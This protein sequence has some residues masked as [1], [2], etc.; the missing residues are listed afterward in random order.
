LVEDVAITR[1]LIG[2]REYRRA[3]SIAGLV[4]IVFLALFVAFPLLT[5]LTRE[6]TWKSFGDLFADVSLRHVI[7]FTTWQALLSTA[8]TAFVAAP[9]VWAL[10]RGPFLGHRVVTGILTMPFVMPTIVVAIA[11]RALLPGS[12][13]GLFPIVLAH[14]LFNVAVYV[15]IVVPRWLSIGTHEEDAARVLGATPLRI[16]TSVIWPQIRVAVRNASCIVGAFTFT[17]FGIIAVLGTSSQRTIELEVLRRATQIGDTSSAVALSFLQ[18]VIVGALL[19]WGSSRFVY[20]SSPHTHSRLRNQS[21]TSHTWMAVIA[22]S[23]S[24][25]VLLPFIALFVRSFRT[26]AGFTLSGWH[27]LI[28]GSL[29]PLGVDISGAVSHSAIFAFVC[30]VIAVPLAVAIS[31]AV[32]YWPQR[33]RWVQTVSFIPL[34]VSAVTLGFGVIITFD[35]APIEWR[36]HWW[37]LP[38]MHAVIAIPLCVRILIPVLTSVDN[39]LRDAAAMLGASPLQ[40]WRDVDIR[41]SRRAIT[42]AVSMALAVSIGEFGATS[43]LTRRDTSTLPIALNRLINHVGD[44]PQNSAYALAAVMAITVSVVMSRA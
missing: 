22:I 27:H 18:V 2:V 19:T 40:R 39:N 38:V 44:I 13:T 26:P 31:S 35:S 28:D 21:R 29:K 12:P 5:L 23:G 4:A 30:A 8:I 34:V 32:S 3:S 14:V 41:S 37:I 16:F 33:M 7:V 11:M 1:E 43:F 6:F 24:V 20:V 15:R 9:L 42:S 17:S 25:L 36:S 10:S